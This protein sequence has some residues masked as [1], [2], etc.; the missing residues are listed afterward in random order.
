MA[1]H[2]HA[3]PFYSPLPPQAL[4]PVCLQGRDLDDIAGYGRNVRVGA[5]AGRGWPTFSLGGQSWGGGDADDGRGNLGCFAVWSQSIV[6][7]QIKAGATGGEGGLLAALDVERAE[8]LHAAQAGGRQV[9]VG[10]VCGLLAT[11]GAAGGGEARVAGQRR[12]SGGGVVLHRALHAVLLKHLF[13]N[14]L[15][16]LDGGGSYR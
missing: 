9:R 1:T 11:T 10:Q 12:T 13:I 6:C 14:K 3:S 8:L 16:V 5:W 15:M 7:F 2:Q 4:C